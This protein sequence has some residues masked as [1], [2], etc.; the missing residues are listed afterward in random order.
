MTLKTMS[1]RND[2]ERAWLRKRLGSAAWAIPDVMKAEFME[3]EF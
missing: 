3:L 2:V 1:E